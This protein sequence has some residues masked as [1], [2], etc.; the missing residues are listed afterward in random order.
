MSGKFITFEGGEGAGKSTQARVLRT[1]LESCGLDVV[2]TREPG[3]SPGAE[4]IR[5]LLVTGEP[6]RWTPLTETLL[7]LAARTDHIAR[8][9]RP[10]LTRG[11]WVVCDRFTDS[12]LVY[13][14]VARGLG[15]EAVNALQSAIP[16][17]L[18][19]DLTILLDVA[20]EDGLRRAGARPEDF[21]TRF[22]KFDAEF[23]DT[24]RMAFRELAKARK[25]RCVMIDAGRSP[26]LVAADIWSAVQDR[27][28]P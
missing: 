5:K 10:A 28:A 26:D 17:M 4:E 20:P 1:A 8:L 12:T 19:P 3:G 9:I 14:G 7:F 23:H 13:Q 2:L 11:D 22:E 21:E 15:V 16:D 25:E 6:D 27:L 18:V 24:L